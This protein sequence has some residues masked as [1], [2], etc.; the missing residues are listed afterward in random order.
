MIRA[1]VSLSFIPLPS[2]VRRP[3]SARIRGHQSTPAAGL[4]QAGEGA[5]SEE[6]PRFR[7]TACHPSPWVPLS[8]RQTQDDASGRGQVSRPLL[9][10]K[11]EV[12]TRKEIPRCGSEPA[13]VT[14]HPGLSPRGMNWT[15]RS[16][17]HRYGRSAFKLTACHLALVLSPSVSS[18]RRL[19]GEEMKRKPP[20]HQVLTF[21]MSWLCLHPSCV[22]FR[23]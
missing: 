13:A 4:S 2:S 6:D 10:G 18:G 5:R 3:T 11:V 7:L 20:A 21:W 17:V 12:V 22:P 14:P 23:P 8:L 1:S 9:D 19:R 16:Q 15:W